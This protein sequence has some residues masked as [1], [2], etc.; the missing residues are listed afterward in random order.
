MLAGSEVLK[1]EGY[2]PNIQKVGYKYQLC[3]CIMP[4]HYLVIWNY[5][6]CSVINIKKHMC[7]N[8][9]EKSV[10]LTSVFQF[11]HIKMSTNFKSTKFIF[12]NFVGK[13]GF[14]TQNLLLI[15]RHTYTL[16][17]NEIIEIVF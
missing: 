11:V 8:I 9:L 4:T 2:H 7:A 12:A 3:Y 10:L 13:N 14:Q 5:E 6:M 17:R 16:K 1:T 15:L